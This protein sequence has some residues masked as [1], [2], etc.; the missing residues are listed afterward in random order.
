MQT[1]LVVIR[2]A[3]IS[4]IALDSKLFPKGALTFISCQKPVLGDDG[5]ILSWEKFSRFVLNQDTGGAIK[6]P[7]RADIF[8]GSGHYAEMAAGHL[9]HPG[10]VYFLVLEPGA[11]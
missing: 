10:T 6:G 8:W 11:R 7:G 3:T 9:Q 2:A 5:E 4:T 1:Y